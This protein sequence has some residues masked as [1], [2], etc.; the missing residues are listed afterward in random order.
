MKTAF[1]NLRSPVQITIYNNIPFDNTYKHHSL[2]SD[3]F[4]YNGTAIYTGGSLVANVPPKERFID[5]RNPDDADEYY[6]PRWSMSGEFNFNYANGLVT[7]VTL[8]LTPE[9]TNA[10]Y[11]KVKCGNDIY[12]YFINSINQINY[13]TYVLTLELDVLMT[14]QDEFLD[15]I[16]D[17]PIFTD[18][19]HSHRYE[20]TGLY[21]KCADL[22]SGESA[23]A[24]IKPNLIKGIDYLHFDC[25]GN[26][27]LEEIKW[28][29]ICHDGNFP[30]PITG[31][32]NYNYRNIEHPLV[33]I[34]LPINVENVVFKDN[35]TTFTINRTTM[36]SV[37]KSLV[38]DGHVKG[39]KISSYPPFYVG[40]MTCTKSGDTYTI[41]F[42]NGYVTASGSDYYITTPKAKVFSQH[43]AQG[44]LFIED[45]YNGDVDFKS[46][47]IEGIANGTRPL[48][49]L[50]RYDDPKLSF[51]PFKKYVLGSTYSNG[52]EFFPE[53]IYSN[54][55]Y[56]SDVFYFG[57]VYTSY[58]GDNNIFTYQKPI[59]DRYYHIHYGSYKENNIGLSAYVN[60][61][62]PTG[63]NALDVFN[64]TQAQSF[65]Q[66]KVASGISSGITIAGGIASVIIGAVAE[67]PTAGASTSLI[68]GGITA[69]AGGVAS[70]VNAIKST[71]AKIEDLRNTPDAVNVQGG[72]FVGDY[73]R[74]EQMPFIAIYE[75]SDAIKQ[76]ANDLFYQYGYQVA[77][78][79]FFNTE[80]TY[81]DD[82]EVDTNLIGRTVFNYIK[83][84]EELVNKINT[85]IPLIVKKKLSSIFNEGITLWSFFGN[86]ELWGNSLV[87]V[88]G[89]IIDDYFLKHYYD[90]TEY[91]ILMG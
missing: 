84:N 34:C 2:I 58:I 41:T 72:S 63:T 73:A 65:Y 47:N 3:R 28:L 38:S 67:M 9:Q 18:R 76:Q 16:K 31:I 86:D 51:N 20:S 80:L 89:I 82:I 40:S 1:P 43:N 30:S 10:N 48:P 12:Y 46:Y 52:N 32:P 36:L 5:R 54:G 61:N 4:T 83:T 57:G 60:Y 26:E 23:F 8:E 29:Y 49:V 45:E 90:N 74:G 33:M 35:D 70:G 88:G 55:F 87:P 56:T 77:R 15:G 22:K 11:M 42:P 25:V 44:L 6:Y 39:C 62:I 27:Y 53:L 21:P 75:C 64:S 24:G 19:K 79:C 66:S 85:D 69:I 91:N 59:I 13:N 50:P 37:I 17:M 7:S 78:D 71:T 14:Y 81:T 68:A